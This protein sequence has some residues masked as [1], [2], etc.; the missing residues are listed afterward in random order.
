MRTSFTSLRRSLQV[1][2]RL[3]GLV[4]VV[5]MV[6]ATLLAHDMWIEPTTFTPEPGDIVGARLRVGQDFIGDPLRRDDALIDQFVV[7][8]AAGRKPLV[9]RPGAD[10]AGLLR[11]DAP[12]LMVIGYR[13]HPSTV[14]QT[15][16]KFN[17]YLTEE[18]LEAIAALRARR[19]ETGAVR[20]LFSRCA[21]SLVLSGTVKPT[22]GD[23]ALGFTLE[24]VAEKNP[25]TT[26]AGQD[27]PVRLTYEGRPLAD[28]LVVAINRN[29]PTEKLSARSDANGR[30]HFRLP[31][32]GPWLIKAVHMIRAKADAQ[33]DWESFWA[34]LT[35]EIR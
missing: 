9:G 7:Q 22:E 10:P 33:A 2:Q 32:G 13:S 31:Q 3:A 8:A 19:G 34:T 23:H 35:F 5:Q 1:V 21:K 14:E 29:N 15:A 6:G 18:G 20:E 28:V 27:L 4:L 24:L 30:V 17:Q 16:E 25:Y 11:V 26:T 12:G